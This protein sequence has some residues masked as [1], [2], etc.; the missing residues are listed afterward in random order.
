MDSMGISTKM[1]ESEKFKDSQALMKYMLTLLKQQLELTR[2]IIKEN[3]RLRSLGYEQY[4]TY[5]HNK[6]KDK[7]TT[8]PSNPVQTYKLHALICE[9]GTF[10]KWEKEFKENK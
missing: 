10:F 8:I 6:R 7:L 5:C 3:E 2:K 9:I 1:V 4:R